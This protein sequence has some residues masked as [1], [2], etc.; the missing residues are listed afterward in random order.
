MLN[1]T[2]FQPDVVESVLAQIDA[3]PTRAAYNRAVYMAQRVEIMDWWGQK[4]SE[5][6][7]SSAL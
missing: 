7:Q 3:N 1:E 4:I 2:G 6:A 5:A